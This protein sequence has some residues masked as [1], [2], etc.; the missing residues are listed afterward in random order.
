MINY[1]YVFLCAVFSVLFSSDKLEKT[2][3]CI[4]CCSGEEHLCFT[5]EDFEGVVLSCDSLDVILEKTVYPEFKNKIC[6]EPTKDDIL[7]FE[8]NFNVFF[9]EKSLNKKISSRSLD[10]Y[11]RQYIGLNVSSQNKILYVIFTRPSNIK[12]FN[13]YFRHRYFNSITKY[14]DGGDTQFIV[15]YDFLTKRFYNFSVNTKG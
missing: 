2:E 15:Y 11:I 12:K 13:N 9:Q 4:L 14:D 8:F 5:E 1:L 10:V 6:W 3:D 7:E